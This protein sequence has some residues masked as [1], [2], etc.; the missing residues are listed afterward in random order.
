[1]PEVLAGIF[2]GYKIVLLKNWPTTPS[3]S[4]VPRKPLSGAVAT[5]SRVGERLASHPPLEA[6]EG[7]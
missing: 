5:V 6:S 2:W 1:M 7:S 4:G 3:V